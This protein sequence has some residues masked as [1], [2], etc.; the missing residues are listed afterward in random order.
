MGQR[1]TGFCSVDL[2]LFS[3]AVG[4]DGTARSLGD[5]FAIG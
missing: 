4:G 1:E 5:G 2:F 3:C